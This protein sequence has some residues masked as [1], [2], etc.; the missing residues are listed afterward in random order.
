[1]EPGTAS[2][3]WHCLSVSLGTA[4]K[5]ASVYTRIKKE[6]DI[7]DH[8]IKDSLYVRATMM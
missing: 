6:H 7:H 2:L 1:M 3:S 8:L 5:S 4:N